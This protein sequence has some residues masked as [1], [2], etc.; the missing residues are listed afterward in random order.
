M[1]SSLSLATT[2]WY[3]MITITLDKNEQT[4]LIQLLDMATKAAGLQGA[5]AAVYFLNKIRSAQPKEEVSTKDQ[6]NGITAKE[7]NING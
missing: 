4:T 7:V 3:K 1:I 6:K 5:E 2:K